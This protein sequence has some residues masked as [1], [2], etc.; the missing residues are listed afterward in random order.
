MRET[1]SFE[2]RSHVFV[3]EFKLAKDKHSHHIARHTVLVQIA[4]QAIL[5][6]SPNRS[7]HGRSTT[8][9]FI[10]LLCLA[11]GLSPEGKSEDFAFPVSASELAYNTSF[12]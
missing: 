9:N 1:S 11:T 2:Q 6:P 3:V 4:L 5:F 10:L 7:S 8:C 12:V